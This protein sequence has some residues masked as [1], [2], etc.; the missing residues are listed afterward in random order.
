LSD[1]IG[2]IDHGELIALGTQEALTQLVGEEDVVAL[3]I[4][5]PEITPQLVQALAQ[6]YGVRQVDAADGT[7]R[8]LAR[9]GNAALPEIIAATNRHNARVSSVSVQE[10]NLEAVFLHLTGRALRD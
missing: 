9:D 4:G 3:Q 5:A 1:R 7:L 6:V 8:L 10:P 2:I